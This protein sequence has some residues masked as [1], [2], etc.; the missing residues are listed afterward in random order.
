VPEASVRAHSRLKRSWLR[1][2]KAGAGSLVVAAA[3]VTASPAGAR[4]PEKL[5]VADKVQEA[6]DALRKGLSVPDGQEPGSLYELAWWGKGWG[7]GGWGW[8]PG[9]HNWPNWHNWHNWPNWP[10][11]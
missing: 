6:R 5:S 2:L 10:N 8:H 7:N 11:G 1:A 4:V 9:W 3:V